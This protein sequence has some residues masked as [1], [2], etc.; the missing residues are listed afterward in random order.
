MRVLA[1]AKVKAVVPNPSS[2]YKLVEFLKAY[3]NW[4]QYVI[5][6]IMLATVTHT[7]YGS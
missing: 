6:Y 3:R 1:T 4:T 2:L 5:I 7:R